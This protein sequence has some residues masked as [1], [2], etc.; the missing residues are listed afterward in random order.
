M[1]ERVFTPQEANAALAQVR[2]VA[3]RMVEC[4]GRLVEARARH[5]AI[6]EK[7]AGNGGG[8]DRRD[9]LEVHEEVERAGREV[10]HCLE[11]LGRL[12][13]VVKSIASGLLDFPA[14]RDGEGV[15]LCWRVGEPEVAY[16][17]G[18]DEGFA[19]RKPLPL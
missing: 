14:V 19:G 16:W 18:L 8:I 13:V 7:V 12:G 10:A 4:H 11:E 5:A 15:L 2:P 3:E 1:A 17:H 6:G 9:V